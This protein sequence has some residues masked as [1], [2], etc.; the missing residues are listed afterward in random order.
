[1]IEKLKHEIIKVL[2]REL[3]TP[4]DYEFLCECVQKR[5]NERLSATTLKR[6]YGYIDRAGSPSLHTLNTLSKYVGYKDFDCFC[7]GN[8]D[9]DSQSNLI[10]GNDLSTAQLISGQEIRLTWRPDRVCVI[11]YIGEGY[12]EVIK[13]E[14]TKL[15]VGDTFCCHLFIKHEPLYLDNLIHVGSQPVAYVAGKKDGINFELL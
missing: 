13:A 15:S 11:K 14:N 10:I 7:Q 6:L 2:G 3:K 12:F 1:M 5:T 4:A 9:I 8:N